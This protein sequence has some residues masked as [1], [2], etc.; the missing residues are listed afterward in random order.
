MAD[1]AL[2]QCDMVLAV[3]EDTINFQ[4]SQ[5]WKRNIIENVW[6]V[7]VRTPAAGT[8]IVKSQADADFDATLAVTVKDVEIN[9]RF[10]QPVN[11]RYFPV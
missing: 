3:S 4:F 11:S 6:K 8:P 7:L 1:T 10:M 9:L 2:G 5:L